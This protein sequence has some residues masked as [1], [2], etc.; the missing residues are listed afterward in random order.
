MELNKFSVISTNIELDKEKNTIKKTYKK[1]TNLGLNTIELKSLIDRYILSLKRAAIPIP[2]VIN[3]YISNERIIY[4]STYCGKNIIEM[5]LN[6]ANFGSFLPQIAEILD[7]IKSAI[8]A[9]LYFDPH[10][11]NFV[12]E[13]SRIYYVDFFPPYCSELLNKRLEIAKSSEVDLIREN[14]SF[15]TKD[16]LT[17]HF[18]GD[19]LNIDK[20]F[21]Q[22]FYLIYKTCV[23]MG[24]SNSNL[25]EFSKKAK[26]I[27]G[28]EDE[29]LAK[30]IY[31][32]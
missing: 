31:L 20:K 16:Y 24:L 10:P 13:D 17:E 32:I 8:N 3:S 14:Y 19:F 27:R 23:E 21:E 15:F 12:F 30:G 25:V 9:D 1:N 18:C 26:Y 22:F 28:L 29:R 6:N 5:G 11:K 4:E 2:E 7:V